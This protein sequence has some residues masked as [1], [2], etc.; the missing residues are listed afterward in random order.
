MITRH[1]Y[2]NTYTW[3]SSPSHRTSASGAMAPILPICSRCLHHLHNKPTTFTTYRTLSTA[4]AITPAPPIHQTTTSV[5]PIAR[6]P[7]TQPPSHKPPEYRKTQLHRQYTSLLRS[8]PLLLLFQH[9]NLKATEWMAIRRELHSALLATD[10]SLNTS[11][12]SH[13]KFQAIQAGIFESALL[14]AEHYDPSSNNNASTPHPTD[15]STSSSAQIPNHLPSPQDPTLTHSLSHHA[16]TTAHPHKKTH[17]LRPLLSGPLATLSFPT[18]SP[19]H[20]R[21]TLSILSPK[22]PTFPAPLRRTN[23]GYWDAT[24][25]GGLQK[26]LLLGARVEGR[27]FDMERIRWVGGLEGMEG[28]RGELVGILGSVGMGVTGA[29]EGVGRGLWMTVEGRRG[30]LEEEEKGKGGE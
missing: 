4:S 7:P 17:P 2:Y 29:L 15:P 1:S 24:T 6:F 14:V 8:A 16:Y 25:Q 9:N 20:I 26:L 22:A 3:L 21:T 30:M 12:A 10:E 13:I 23:P 27:V 18:L 11:Y 28:L 5:P 19:P